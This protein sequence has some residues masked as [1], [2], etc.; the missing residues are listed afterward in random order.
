M[1]R[2]IVLI[3]ALTLMPLPLF[4]KSEKEKN[5]KE[6]KTKEETLSSK[7]SPDNET[8]KS[9]KQNKKDGQDK[10]DKKDKQEKQDKKEKQDKQDKK[11]KKDE[12]KKVT[13]ETFDETVY[14]WMRTFSENIELVKSKHYRIDNLETAFI[15]SIEAFLSALDPHSNLLDPKTYKLMLESTSGEFFGIGVVIDNTRKAK[16]RFLLIIDTIPNGP[17][18]KEEVKPLDKIV[19]IDGESIE[20]MTTEEAITKIKGK[21]GTSVEL[22]LTRE[23]HPEMIDVE[24]TRDAVKEQNSLSFE[25]RDHN[26]YYLSLNMFTENAIRQVEDLLK[27]ASEK[28]YKGIILDLRNNSG[29]L[30][31]SSIDIAGLFLEKGSFVVETK[32]RRKTQNEKYYTDRKPI[33]GDDIPIFILINNYTA[34]AAEILAGC[35]KQ[36]ADSG[37]K[38]KRSHVFLVGTNTFGKGSVQ[39]VIPISNSCAAKITSA[40]YFLP[41]DISIQGR[42]I[43]P[44]FHVERCFP[45]TEQVKWFTENYGREQKLENYIKVDNKGNNTHDTSDSKEEKSSKKKKDKEKKEKDAS[46]RWIERAQEMMKTD[47]QLRMAIMLINI[48]EQIKELSPDKIATRK[49]TIQALEQNL[50]KSD[51]LDLVEIKT[52]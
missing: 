48:L 1:K 20:G 50:V 29:G 35:L 28:K 32:D 6:L 7:Q 2:I 33:A 30:L 26:I 10:K 9:D 41:G 11:D 52:R 39:E 47:N 45:P 42:G 22:K 18:D 49:K 8:S 21:K 46:G 12:P 31:K 14:S 36:H 24:I 5:T 23:G 27:Q 34:S 3:S 43:E 44:D 51:K 25:I 16:D 38:T 40:L 19:E 13:E 17:A 4:A 37:E 15:K